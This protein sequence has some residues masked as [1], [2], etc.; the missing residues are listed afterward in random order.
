M[1]HSLWIHYH[2]TYIVIGGAHKTA[3]LCWDKGCGSLSNIHLAPT[4]WQA[5]C[6]VPKK[7]Q[8]TRQSWSCPHGTHVL[9]STTFR[10]LQQSKTNW[11]AEGCIEPRAWWL[12]SILFYPMRLI[13]QKT[14][15]LYI[16]EVKVCQASQTTFLKVFFLKFDFK[17]LIPWHMDIIW[18]FSF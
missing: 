7:E 4:M 11:P 12:F 8:R 5:M 18:C 3:D 2:Q 6:L 17:Q 9:V 15:K 13:Y 16:L 14:L 1:S 10:D